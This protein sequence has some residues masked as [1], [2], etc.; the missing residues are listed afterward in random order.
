MK[1]FGQSFV[2]KKKASSKVPNL[3][4]SSTGKRAS[5]YYT[6]AHH[7]EW[8]QMQQLGGTFGTVSISN[9]SSHR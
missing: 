6:T 7:S 9:C 2:T 1:F 4:F 5:K 3:S 8:S